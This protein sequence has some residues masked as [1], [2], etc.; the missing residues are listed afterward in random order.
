MYVSE[1]ASANARGR[2]VL[3]QGFFAIGSIVLAT[4]IEFGLFF[5]GHSQA[6]F[7]FPVALQALFAI[8]S[9][10]SLC[11]C[12]SLLDGWSSVTAWRMLAKF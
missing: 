2:M 1:C 5:S 12:L 11:S 9:S 7:R 10:P 4:W 3:M 8:M 6:N